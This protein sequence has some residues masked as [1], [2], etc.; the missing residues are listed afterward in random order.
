M[1]RFT[2]VR[3]FQSA[4]PRL[5]PPAGMAIHAAPSL[6]NSASAAKSGIKQ[7]RV[8]MMPAS[9]LKAAQASE[10]TQGA[11]TELN[12]GDAYSTLTS[13]DD[14]LSVGTVSIQGHGHKVS[15]VA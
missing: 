1:F 4:A 11:A 9:E 7:G 10:P 3:R 14:I 6:V 2:A 8:A 15:T 13:Q 5:Q 12:A